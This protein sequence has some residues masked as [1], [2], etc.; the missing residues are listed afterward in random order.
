M[1]KMDEMTKNTFEGL[2]FQ[3]QKL[4]KALAAAAASHGRGFGGQELALAR[5]QVRFARLV[6]QDGANVGGINT[7]FTE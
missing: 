4:E 2:I 5:T 6:L 1:D 7:A 3:A